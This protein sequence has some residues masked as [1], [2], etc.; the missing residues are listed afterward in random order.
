MKTISI[1]GDS[2]ST[3]KGYIPKD[4]STWYPND[5]QGIDSVKQTWWHLL[6]ESIGLKLVTNSS[7]N[8]STICNTG[9]GGENS[10]YSS[11]VTRLETDLG[12]EKKDSDFLII[13]G[14]TNDFWAGSPIGE[15]KYQD[16]TEENL[17]QFAPAFAYM[18]HYAKQ[19]NKTSKIYCVINDELPNYIRDIMLEVCNHYDIAVVELQ[20]VDKT[21][22]HP[23][24]KGMQT[25]AKS[26][27]EA[28]DI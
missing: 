15:I 10:A 8:G 20:G 9:Y 24:V 27:Q 16:W 19:W 17:K 1:L 22:G 2:Y 5:E 4:Y 14:A 11:F 21:N 3:F 13:F 6:C 25:I 18:M 26:L 7:Y 28:L 12:K 23:T